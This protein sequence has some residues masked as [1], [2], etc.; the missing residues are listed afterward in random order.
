MKSI[1]WLAAVIGVLGCISIADADDWGQWLGPK[2]DSVWRETGIATSFPDGGPKVKWRAPIS[3]GFSGPAVVGDRVYV[4]DYVKTKGDIT[5]NPGKRDQLM[6]QERVLC[7]D[8]NT[9]KILWEHSDEVA[10]SLSYPGGPRC[11]PTV[12]GDHLYMLGAEGNLN[13]LSTADGK[14]VWAREL[15]KDYG[16]EEAPIWGFAA[17]P[18]VHSDT[19]YCVVGGKGSVAVAFDKKT[20]AENGATCLQRNRGIVPRP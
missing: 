5:N 15:K 17:H 19:L 9:G 3:G 14:V 4:C 20:G 1:K 6:G 2:R 18:L 7:L 8:A 16:L 12:D 11:T 10:Y 13:C